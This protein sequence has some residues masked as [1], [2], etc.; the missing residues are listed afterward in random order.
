MSNQE[1]SDQSESQSGDARRERFDNPDLGSGVRDTGTDARNPALQS[2]PSALW[3]L[4][5]IRRS[6]IRPSRTSTAARA[7]YPRKTPAPLPA[8]R[9]SKPERDE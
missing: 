4:T 6:A 7:S 3:T 5:P 8:V 2:A 9:G 1:Q